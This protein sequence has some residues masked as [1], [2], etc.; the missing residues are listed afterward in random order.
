[1]DQVE[2]SMLVDIG[3]KF[4]AVPSRPTGVTLRSMSLVIDFNRFSGKAQVRRA[5]LSCDSSYFSSPEPN[6]H[7]VSL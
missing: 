6:A 3:L 1:M 5:T 7:K 4:Y 2:L